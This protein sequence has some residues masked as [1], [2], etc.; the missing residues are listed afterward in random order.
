MGG[1]QAVEDG[2]GEGADNQL[3]LAR[4]FKQRHAGRLAEERSRPVSEIENLTL[5]ARA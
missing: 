5:R 2:K 1:P 3:S 4:V